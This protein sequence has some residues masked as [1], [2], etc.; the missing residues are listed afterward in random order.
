ME[1]IKSGA[2]LCGCRENPV[3]AALSILGHSEISPVLRDAGNSGSGVGPCM[4]AG[5]RDIQG[6]PQID[7]QG[8]IED[9]RRRELVRPVWFNT[10][11]FVG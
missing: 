11:N 10:E 1:M 7:L 5:S 9:C 8:L 4:S 2:S 6:R 3:A